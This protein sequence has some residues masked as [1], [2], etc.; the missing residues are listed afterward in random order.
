MILPAAGTVP[1]DNRIYSLSQGATLPSAGGDAPVSD[2]DG[3]TTSAD[4]GSLPSA[5]VNIGMDLAGVPGPVQ[6]GVNAVMSSDSFSQL[7]DSLLSSLASTLGSAVTNAALPGIPGLPSIGGALAGEAT[8]QDSNYGAAALSSGINA[9]AAL[10][11]TALA[12]PIGGLV[13]GA[14][15]SYAVKSSLADGWLG[16]MVDSRTSEAKRDAVE[17]A[18]G[19]DPSDTA[20]MASTQMGMDAFGV[21][22]RGFGLDAAYGSTTAGQIAASAKQSGFDDSSLMGYLDRLD[23]IAREFE[24]VT[25]VAKADDR[26]PSNNAGGFLGDRDVDSRDRS[27]DSTPGGL[28]GGRDGGGAGGS[29]GGGVGAGTSDGTASGPGGDQGGESSKY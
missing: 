22:D 16:D 28:L 1:T 17:S 5:G 14:L 15:S 29:S 18:F 26:N 6:S 11:G 10:A 7:Q 8:K 3:V 24:D 27:D 4:L 19:F 9:G 21:A 20:G 25:T 2:T 12:G 13:A 23:T